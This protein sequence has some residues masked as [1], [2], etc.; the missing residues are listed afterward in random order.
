MATEISA[1]I[2]GQG[3]TVSVVSGEEQRECRAVIQVVKQ[4]Q[5]QF[6]PTA[7]GL[8]DGLKYLYLGTAGVPLS[9]QGDVVLWNGGRF[10]VVAAHPVYW[11][12]F[13]AYWRGILEPMAE[14]CLVE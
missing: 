3:T 6:T 14:D 9:S 8:E 1:L 13:I 4:N 10:A 11:G 12:S 5:A 2:Q 7:Y